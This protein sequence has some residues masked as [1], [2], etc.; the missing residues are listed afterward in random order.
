ME[1]AA[2]PKPGAE[3]KKPDVLKQLVKTVLKNPFIW[4]MVGF[5]ET[6][7]TKC[8]GETGASGADMPLLVGGTCCS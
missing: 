1:P 3:K 4:G 8:C 7:A 6:H 5:V 2:A